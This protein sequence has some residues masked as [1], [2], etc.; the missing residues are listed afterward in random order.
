M[1]EN[2]LDWLPR[3]ELMTFEEM[4]RLCSVFV[5]MG[6]NKIRITGGEPFLRKD[7]MAFL[8]RVSRIDGLEQLSITTNG[9]RIAA[10]IP[11]LKA[12]GIHAVN[13]SLDTLDK[14]RFIQITRRDGL[15]QVLKTLDALLA[16]GI[17]VKVNTVVME[18]R[19]T[20]DIIP[21]VKLAEWLPVS[22]RFIEEM[23]FNGG[24]HSAALTWDHRRIYQHIEQHFPTIADMA[25]PRHATARRYKVP[26]HKGDIGII[27]AYTRLFCGSCNRIRVTPTGMV[28]ACLYDRGTFN[29]KDTMR[30]GATDEELK[31]MM[32]QAVLK[33]EIDGWAAEKRL[34]DAHHTHTSMA[35][36][37]G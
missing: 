8:T 18:N 14:D 19:N 26:G 1:P 7:L 34:L 37:G 29:I 13:L 6:G 28:Q 21:L 27:A 23:P 17:E 12:I 24:N 5:R 15:D 25:T 9:L 30:D 16:H 4:F 36:I 20:D 35:T 11:E 22:I 2:G 33:K 31:R 32:E 3:K 10:M